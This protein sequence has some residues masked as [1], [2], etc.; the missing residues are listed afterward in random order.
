MEKKTSF[1]S[2]RHGSLSSAFLSLDFLM[3]TRWLPA[4]TKANDQ[5]KDLS[6]A[7]TGP[8]LTITAP[9]AMPYA[10]AWDSAHLIVG[11]GVRLC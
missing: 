11:M 10:Y 6:F 8:V 3:F 1:S 5:M 2:W 4:A 9:R 7:L